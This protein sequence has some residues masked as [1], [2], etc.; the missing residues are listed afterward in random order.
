NITGDVYS[1]QLGFNAEYIRSI[2]SLM[3]TDEMAL[4]ILANLFDY[5]FMIA[6]GTF[7]FSL[8]LMLTRKLQ[9]GSIWNQ[10]G[11][12]IAIAGIIA[13]CCDGIENIFLLLMASN[14]VNFPNWLAIPHSCFALAK[15][16]LLFTSM[17]WIVLTIIL[18]VILGLI[19]R[20]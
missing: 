2:F 17:G 14:P 5:L 4:L 9:E 1:L 13:A 10:I 15:F 18:I 19:K 16:I 3:S 6:Y 20:K 11:Y 7:I 12:F 8:A